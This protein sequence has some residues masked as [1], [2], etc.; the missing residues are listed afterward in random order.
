[1]RDK[2]FHF[3]SDVRLMNTLQ[4]IWNMNE[5]KTMS[6]RRKASRLRSVQTDNLR[7]IQTNNDYM[8]REN[9]TQPSIQ[10]GVAIIG[11]TGGHVPPTFWLA[12]N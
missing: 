9:A 7:I 11:R 6:C 8:R 4:G 5:A 3:Y 2:E 12:K 1:V 10:A